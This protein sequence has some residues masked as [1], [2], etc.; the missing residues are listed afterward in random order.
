MPPGTHEA[1]M[2]EAFQRTAAALKPEA[3]LPTRGEAALH[4]HQRFARARRYGMRRS[5]VM[6]SRSIAAIRIRSSGIR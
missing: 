1:R 2:Q 4:R 3:A 6:G 5:A